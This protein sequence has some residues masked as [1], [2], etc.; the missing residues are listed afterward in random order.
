MMAG[1][2]YSGTI[3]AQKPA[4]GECK[5]HQKRKVPFCQNAQKRTFSYLFPF[6]SS[7]YRP[8]RFRSLSQKDISL[9]GWSWA[10][11]S[12]G[13]SM[14]WVWRANCRAVTP[15]FWLE[16]KETGVWAPDRAFSRPLS[17]SSRWRLLVWV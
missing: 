2:L 9:A 16:V 13:S 14:G 5:F 17:C 11:W 6:Y 10:V 1:C 4:G 7:V 8:N 12:T 3:V 15:V